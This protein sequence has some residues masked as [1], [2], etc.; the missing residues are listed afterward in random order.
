MAT[1][2]IYIKDIPGG[3]VEVHRQ[4]ESGV[5]GAKSAAASLAIFATD[6]I[7]ELAEREGDTIQYMS[8]TSIRAAL[9]GGASHG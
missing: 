2:A 5:H 8:Q 4:L 3:G 9:A 1:Y 7:K 6:A